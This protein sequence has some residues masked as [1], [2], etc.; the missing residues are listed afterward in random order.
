MGRKCNYCGQAVEEEDIY[1][2]GCGKFL[3]KKD[4]SEEKPEH[5]GVNTPLSLWDC[6]FIG[7]ILLV[8][9][10]NVIVFLIWAF[11]KQGNINRKNLAKAGLIYLGIGFTLTLI[12]GVG[13]MRAMTLDRQFYPNYNYFEYETEL[14]EFDEFMPLPYEAE[15]T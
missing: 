11:D 10:V 4:I 3:D 9:V 2:A 14:P 13:I 1:C 12:L 5:Y 8:P 7:L 6:M 15:E